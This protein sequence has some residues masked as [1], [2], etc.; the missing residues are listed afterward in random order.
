LAEQLEKALRKHVAFEDRV[1]LALPRELPEEERAGLGRRIVDAIGHA[2]TRPHPH[3]PKRPGG[4]VKAAAAGAATVDRARDNIG[5]RPAERRGRAE[6]EPPGG[7]PVVNGL[8][9]EEE[10]D[11]ADR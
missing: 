8:R 5:D 10:Q 4:V 3:A 11:N 1:L 2:P 7:A 9:T 6:E